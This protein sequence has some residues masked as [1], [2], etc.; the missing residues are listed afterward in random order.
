MTA[1]TPSR[2]QATPSP[3]VG[4]RLPRWAAVAGWPRSSL[5]AAVGLSAAAVLDG[6]DDHVFTAVLLF[7]IVPDRVVVLGRRAGGGPRTGSP[8]R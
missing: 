2:R 1:L 6:L 4:A 3:L 8:R 5:V 7:L